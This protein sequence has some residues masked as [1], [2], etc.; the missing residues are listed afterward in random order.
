MNHTKLKQLVG[1]ILASTCTS[2]GKR[3]YVAELNNPKGTNRVGLH[4]GSR[5]ILMPHFLA[6]SVSIV[7]SKIII[8]REIPLSQVEF[9]FLNRL[10]KETSSNT[11]H[12]SINCSLLINSSSNSSL[13]RELFSKHQTFKSMQMKK[14]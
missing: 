8:N 3:P 5:C 14:Q 1:P 9:H 2:S 12:I 11:E 10:E 13:K 7:M 4:K 6:Q